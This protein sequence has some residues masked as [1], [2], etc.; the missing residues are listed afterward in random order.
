MKC[1]NGLFTVILVVLAL[2]V[3]LVGGLSA[4]AMLTRRDAN[5]G[6]ADPTI[7]VEPV[8]VTSVPSGPRIAFT[9]HREGNS[10][11]YVMDADGS[12]AQRVSDPGQGF[13]FSPSWS[14]D[15]QHIAYMGTERNPYREDDL[16]TSVWVSSLDGLEH[17]HAS[18]TVSNVLP[19]RPTWSPDG[20][21]LA[22]ASM[23]EPVERGNPTSIVHVARVDGVIERSI[24]LPWMVRSI[25]WSPTKDE[26]L[27][28]GAVSEQT[29]SSVYL[30]SGEKGEEQ[31][32]DILYKAQTVD[33]SPDGETIVIGGY[34]FNEV[35]IAER[36]GDPVPVAQL[37]EMQPQSLAWSP[38][39]AYIAVESLAVVQQGNGY[40]FFSA[41]QIFTVDTGE[42]TTVVEKDEM[43]IWEPN[44]SPDSNRLLFTTVQATDAE[45]PLADLWVYDIV[46]EESEQLTVGEEFNGLG[47][48]SP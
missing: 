8:A 28:V 39:G 13:F 40:V 24:P 19:L 11:V 35:L 20:E 1:K 17:I 38:N 15:G 26:W 46:S 12:N 3:L 25:N 33:W 2:S 41:L 10:A 27:V 14:P 22:F 9:S 37:N 30:L 7:T 32:F 44:W 34:S 23:V 36:D 5:E 6:A 48:W 4:C 31:I 45:L 29:E 42:I 18:Q 47:V 16:Q 21:R 43:W